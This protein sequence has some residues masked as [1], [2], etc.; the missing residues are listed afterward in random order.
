MNAGAVRKSRALAAFCLFWWL[1]CGVAGPPSPDA[2]L[3]NGKIIYSC[4][5]SGA[6]SSLY[7][8][9]I[10]PACTVTTNGARTLTQY[11]D[12]PLCQLNDTELLT[13]AATGEAWWIQRQYRRVWY[14]KP[15]NFKYKQTKA[16]RPAGGTRRIAGYDCRRYVSGADLIMM[17]GAASVSVWA[18]EQ[19]ALQT[20]A[21]GGAP[22]ATLQPPG[23]PGYMLRKEITWKALD[24]K[25]IWEAV[26]VSP[27]AAPEALEPPADY[28][29]RTFDPMT[30]TDTLFAAPKD[31]LRK[32]SSE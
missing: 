10:A 29:L 19:L 1:A 6:D 12:C 3:F 20:A 13:D 8:P 11:A 9:Y 2:P 32:L 27:G 24:L 15:E 7:A 16:F 17:G 31:S 5:V 28:R 18:S 23:L 25:L 21:G 30:K 26:T 4:R 22:Y 14:F